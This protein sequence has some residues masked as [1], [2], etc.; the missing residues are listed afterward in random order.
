ML[1]LGPINFV[2]LDAF[3]IVVL[4]SRGLENPRWATLM[5]GPVL[6][7]TLTKVGTNPVKKSDKRGTNQ[8]VK[9]EPKKVW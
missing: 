9:T 6:T 5:L 8:S 1:V 3:A 7:V 2:E 4:R